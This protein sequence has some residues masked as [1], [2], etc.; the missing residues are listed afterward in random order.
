MSVSA[1]ETLARRAACALDRAH[2][3]AP[4]RAAGAR[5][6]ASAAALRAAFTAHQVF[7]AIG[8]TLEGPVFHLSRRVQQLVAQPPGRAHCNESVL[9]LFAATGATP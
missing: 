5:L 3:D 4:A 2:A 1:A 8:I 7:G 9:S 6:S